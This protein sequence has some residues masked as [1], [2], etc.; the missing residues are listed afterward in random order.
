MEDC[1]EDRI[2][3][4]VPKKFKQST[5]GGVHANNHNTFLKNT[6]IPEPLTWR[7][8]FLVLLLIEFLCKTFAL[9][10]C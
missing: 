3:N 9:N 4:K 5:C 2:K 6:F 10:Q 8:G 7:H 1:K